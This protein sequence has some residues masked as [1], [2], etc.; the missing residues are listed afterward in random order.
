MQKNRLARLHRI[1]PVMAGSLMKRK[2]QTGYYLTDKMGGKTRT[3]YVSD[4]M[5]EEAK[6]WNTNYKEA[7]QLLKELSEIQRVLLRE[8]GKSK[9]QGGT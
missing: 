4:E 7:K 3:S 8:E 6:Q 1:G 9:R 2:D 5:Y